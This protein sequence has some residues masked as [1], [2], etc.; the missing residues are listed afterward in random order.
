[1]LLAL[2]HLQVSYVTIERTRLHKFRKNI[3]SFPQDIGSFFARMGALRQYRVGDRVNSNRG[4]PLP[5]ED[6]FRE[7][8]RPTTKE[9]RERFAVDASGHLVFAATVKDVAAD[10]RLV[11]EYTDADGNV[12]GEGVEQPDW[13]RPRV[14][15]P[16]HPS[17]LKEALVIM[18]RRNVGHGRVLEGLEVRWGLVVRVL[19]A[20]TKL[21]LWRDSEVMGPMHAAYDPRLFDVLSEEEVRWKYAPK[22][23]Q[24]ELVTG[25]R[26][27]ELKSQGKDAQALDVRTA[28]EL[29]ASGFSVQL[30][31]M[32]PETGGPEFQ[33]EEVEQEV[34]RKWLEV[35]EFRLGDALGRWWA[36]LPLQED[37]DSRDA[38][39][40]DH[41]D[42]LNDFH[43][44]LVR[45]SSSYLREAKERL[46]NVGV[47]E[48]SFL[49]E[50]SM[51]RA[52][53]SA[54]Q[55]RALA[56]GG[57]VTIPFL[58]LWCRSQKDLAEFAA[59]D[60]ECQDLADEVEAEMRIVSEHFLM[61]ARGC[62]EAAPESNDVEAEALH[63]AE[64]L[65][66]PEV[67]WPRVAEEPTAYKATGRFTRALPL[68]FP[69]GVAD[70][71]DIRHHA[72]T[73]AEWVQ[74][75]F[76]HAAG[77]C[78]Q[79]LRGHREVWAFVN[80]I[81]LQEAAGK[82]FAVQRNV[83]RRI[84]GRFV[85]RRVTTK[86]QLREMIEDEDAVR[87]LVHQLMSVGRDVRST[88]MHWAYEAKKTTCAVNHLSWRPPWVRSRSEA[89]EDD[90][91]IRF[92]GNNERVV[93]GVGLGR[94][95]VFWWT[96]NCA[97]NAAYDIHRLNCIDPDAEKALVDT[98]DKYRHVRYN[99]IRDR[100]DLAA[101]MV[102]FRAE[103]N[104]RIVMPTIVPHSP[105]APYLG[106]ARFE[107]GKGANPHYHGASYGMGNPRLGFMPCEHARASADLSPEAFAAAAA[108]GENAEDGEEVEVESVRP[109]SSSAVD[110]PPAPPPHAEP[111]PQ[112]R[113]LREQ[114]TPEL[115][116]RPMLQ[117]SRLLDTIAA[118]SSLDAQAR[119][120]FRF[121]RR[122]VSEWNPCCAE[123]GEQRVSFSWDGEVG[124]HD[125]VVQEPGSTGDE[126][127]APPYTAGVSTSQGDCEPSRVRLS[128]VLAEVLNP[129]DPNAA[130]DLTKVRRLVSAL[131]Q[132]CGRHDR[133]AK[134]GPILGKHPC[135][136]GKPECPYCRYGFPH[137]R[138]TWAEGMSLEKGEREGQWAAHF[139]RNDGLVNSHEV[140]VLLANMGNIDWR[141][142]LN[143][144][145]VVEYICKYAT[146][147]PEGSKKLGEM[148]GDAVDEVCKY[149]R[150]GEPVDFLRKSL[151][152]LYTR[153]LG[154]RDYTIFEAMFLGL[155]LPLMLSLMPVV[156]LNTT[157]TRALK[158]VAQM[159]NAGPDAEIS[160]RSKVDKFDE[161]LCLL[162]RQFPRPEQDPLRLHWEGLIR[163]TSLQEFYWKYNV[164]RG[165]LHKTT[166]DVCIMVTPAVSAAAAC[167]LHDRHD[168]YART[169]V[170]AYWRCMPSTDRARLWN[171]MAIKEPWFF[172]GTVL[173]PP[174]PHAGA[175]PS[176]QDRFVGVQD[177]VA[178]FDE[179]RR[180]EMVWST[181]T[182][183][184]AYP[185]RRRRFSPGVT[186]GWSFALMEMLVDPVLLEW[187][188]EYVVEQYKRWNPYFVD[189]LDQVTS[190]WREKGAKLSPARKTNRL[191]L[192]KVRARMEAAQKS[193][194]G[195][196]KK[197]EDEQAARASGSD[198]DPDSSAGA[199]SPDEAEQLEANARS[200]L[201]QDPLPTLGD[202]GPEGESAPDDWAKATAEERLSA[203]GPCQ[204]AP[205]KVLSARPLVSGSCAGE[206]NPEGYDWERENFVPRG[207]ALKLQ[208]LW[209]SWC[210]QDVFSADDLQGAGAA[211]VGCQEDRLDPW[212]AFARDI[213]A[214]RGVADPGASPPL[215]LIMTGT[216]GTGK[217]RT[218]KAAVRARCLRRVMGKF[219]AKAGRRVCVLAAPTGC[220]SFQL[221]NGATTVHRAFG[222]PVGF[223]GK[224]KNRQT[225]AF[226]RRQGRLRA[227]EVF[228]IDEFSMVGRQMMGKIVFKVRECL[229]GS[230][231]LG[232]KDAVLSGDP[233]QAAPIGE[234]P[235]FR[236]GRYEG[237]GL[238]KPRKGDAP[239]G[240]PSLADL[241]RM[242]E[243]LREE[244]QD[245]VILRNV[246]R[247]CRA[248][249]GMD[250]AAAAQYEADADR[251]LEVTQ[252]M[253]N[254]TWTLQDHAWLARRN[255]SALSKT[256]EGRAKLEA[257]VEAPLLMDGKRQ[258]RQG[259]D[260][261]TRLNQEELFRMAAR[262][263]KPVLGIPAFHGGYEQGSLPE[264]M[265]DEDFKGLE[266][267]LMLCVGARVLLTNNLWVEA[268]LM[269]GAL[270]TVRGFIWPEGGDPRAASRELRA[271]VCVVVEFDEIDLGEEPAQDES[272]NP[273]VRDGR[274]V[275][276]R[277]CF[278][279]SLVAAMGT[280]TAGIP[281]ACR[282]VPIYQF[283][284]T[285]ESDE[286]VSRHQFPLVLAWALTHWKA[287]G[288][289]LRRA[290]IRMGQRTASQPGIGFV[291]NTRVKHPTHM[292]FDTDLPA[293][294][295]F[296]EAQW[297]QNFRAR[298]RFEW[299]L[300]AKASHTLRKYGF[301]G[302]DEWSVKDASIAQALLSRLEK[303]GLER[304]RDMGLGS[305]PDAW[306]WPSDQVP[307]EALLLRQVREHAGDDAEL[308]AQTEQ[309][310]QRLLGPWHKPA[311]LEA[312]G[313]LIPGAFHPRH[314]G[315]KPRGK[316]GR[317]P[318]MAVHLQA[319]PWK[320]DAFEEQGLT[321]SAPGAEGRLLKGVLEF[322]LIVLRR[323]CER[324]SLPI[325][326]GTHRLGYDLQAAQTEEDMALMLLTL[327]SWQQWERMVANTAVAEA[328]LVPVALDDNNV[329]RDC[330]L[331]TV[332]PLTAGQRLGEAL[333]YKVDVYDVVGRSSLAERLCRNM[334]KLLSASHSSKEVQLEQHL[335]TGGGTP[336]ERGFASMG[337]LL[338]S[339][340]AKAGL[341][342]HDPV[343]P[344]FAAKVRKSL[345]AC[346]ASLRSEADKRGN[347]DVLTQLATAEACKACLQVL[348]S[349]QEVQVST[350]AMQVPRQQPRLKAVTVST[351]QPLKVL[352]W[353]ISGADKSSLAPK[354]FSMVDKM[355]AIQQEI[356]SRW[357]PDVCT[358]QECVDERP[359]PG[360]V[361]TYSQVGVAPAEHSGYI[362][363]YV[364]QGLCAELLTAPADCP[365]VLA[366]ITVSEGTVF[367]V[368]AV[369]LMPGECAKKERKAQLQAAL[370]KMRPGS[371]LLL[372]DM[373]VRPEEVR[374]L[375]AMGH[376]H[377]AEYAGRSWHPSK[378]RYDDSEEL[379]AYRGPGFAFDRV[380]FTGALCVET[381]LLGQGRVY[382]EGVCFSLS[383]HFAV[384]GLVDLHASHGAAA[385]GS[386]VRRERR[387]ALTAVRDQVCF[388]E[389][390]VVSEMS[391]EGRQEAAAQWARTDAKAQA[392]AVRVQRAQIKE[393]KAG[394][395]AL[396]AD[397]FGPQSAFHGDGSLKDLP[398]TASEACPPVGPTPCLPPLAPWPAET[399]GAAHVLAQVFL[400]LGVV[401]SWLQ[402]HTRTCKLQR[403]QCMCCALASMGH[404]FQAEQAK[405]FQQVA[406]LSVT[407]DLRTCARQV[408]SALSAKEEPRGLWAGVGQPPGCTLTAVDS[409][410]AFPQEVCERCCDCGRISSR[411]EKELVMDLPSPRLPTTRRSVPDLYIQSCCPQQDKEAK[412]C[413]SERCAGASTVHVR[414]ARAVRLPD[415]L[416]VS[417]DRAAGEGVGSRYPVHADDY[418]S[419]HG[420][421]NAELAAVVYGMS[422][423]TGRGRYTCAIRGPD[424]CFW[425]F[426]G[427]RPPRRLQTDIADLCSHAVE[428]LVYLPTS[429][430]FASQAVLGQVLRMPAQ[431]PKSED[432]LPVPLGRPGAVGHRPTASPSGQP[433]RM[434]ASSAGAKPA[435]KKEKLATSIRDNPLWHMLEL[436]SLQ[437][438]QAGE[439]ELDLE[440]CFDLPARPKK[441]QAAMEATRLWQKLVEVLHIP[442][443]V[444]CGLLAA[445]RGRF[446]EEGAWSL[447]NAAWICDLE[448][449][450]HF[451]A[452]V[453]AICPAGISEAMPLVVRP[454]EEVIFAVVRLV[455]LQQAA[456][457]PVSTTDQQKLDELAAAGWQR[458]SSDAWDE[459]DCLVDSLAQV[460]EA[461]GIIAG[462]GPSGS[463]TQADRKNACT[464]ARQHL[465]GDPALL[466]RDPYGRPQWDAYLQ[467][468]RHAETLV[469][470]LVRRFSA[471]QSP[472]PRAGATLVVHAR[473][474]TASV[475]AERVQICVGAGQR[476]PAPELHLFNW[477]GAGLRGYHYDALVRSGSGVHFEPLLREQSTAGSSNDAALAVGA[478]ASSSRLKRT[479][480]DGRG[481][482]GHN[483]PEVLD[484][485]SPPRHALPGNASTAVLDSPRP[486]AKAK[487]QAQ[488]RR[489]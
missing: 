88:P 414:Q 406:A 2:E 388:Q 188:P 27:E 251:F 211:D 408:L 447:S 386:E 374:D 212:Q 305:D 249:E 36:E 125:V 127:G 152:K 75:M 216:A 102:A 369:H 454:A 417:V 260:G 403:L 6:D 483:A 387:G 401:A 450:S 375:L 391:R 337:V 287:Q 195:E 319:G 98:S 410:F 427:R 33:D 347:R 290:R 393:R 237:K 430:S 219:D 443:D 286:K 197:D 200:L 317:E 192:R 452:E 394:R 435:G 433:K 294:E 311:V 183:G 272:G 171:A 446:G 240:A 63:L 330:V 236:Y 130:V 441:K 35:R 352:S 37:E 207:Q 475:P 179:R 398:S 193:K 256:P 4:P 32:D 7:A 367:D 148:L 373:N 20:L 178:A 101:Y 238:N 206:V 415:V 384:M 368:A 111:R 366:R 382:S 169:C 53:L 265:F 66:A 361:A 109:V 257:F 150:D 348:S 420:C 226:A 160:W 292:V 49:L 233:K 223:C 26:A 291:A 104:M 97:Y 445:L 214:R 41:D 334:V 47:A 80:T 172:G 266:A 51:Q 411:Y 161:R 68:S 30:L 424:T 440:P 309:V 463:L 203:A 301:C 364:R 456:E 381:F 224:A 28:A 213:I 3:I 8:R 201:V 484:L 438:A 154:G 149:T 488:P 306:C 379:K 71:Y 241:T 329:L 11:L 326:L 121:F 277:R 162:R 196:N 405:A 425:F 25:E 350:S 296:Q 13:V 165:R 91:R 372:G 156:S 113:V 73:E 293:W 451:G 42:N 167:V 18:L 482:A 76:R 96:Q 93:D 345:G 1:M 175:R 72:V 70:M 432:G 362:H 43:A 437:A 164:Y 299:R 276:Q 9:E 52:S 147:A 38:L 275:Y 187:V 89:E 389:Q 248:P 457:I 267:I 390:C 469:W 479:P 434:R 232:G 10:G 473:Y 245:V 40:T 189:F 413:P 57:K 132:K 426:D 485:S 303:K 185:F 244:F 315:K 422:P 468:H 191:F 327:Q 77:L 246:H 360:L 128:E 64:S 383:D 353:N 242:G 14:Q 472:L 204:A 407:A 159:Q 314:D 59:D 470:F 202:D 228:I 95:P 336:Y 142:C 21:G 462:S 338:A 412:A 166:Q 332:A 418:I 271:P 92:L 252:G 458:R 274:V 285:A 208:G 153:T 313:C 409:L 471:G 307:V 177:L 99:F 61:S 62:M 84:G 351:F 69:M 298:R 467:H 24:G 310:A 133:H 79:G 344:D 363:L 170:V 385:H 354:S 282:C 395:D 342:F 442:A 328:F 380:F 297:K 145:A 281:R 343:A 112:K 316:P 144:W 184:G 94:I 235:M 474:D 459:N 455:L 34:F 182:Q 139:P 300:E 486:K 419:L 116:Q 476:G 146:K 325:V 278:F 358:L 44:Q 397:A 355:A 56:D 174:L 158:T 180:E 346:F 107:C 231:T 478:A 254:C 268:G 225:V 83:M 118:E 90:D 376:L 349:P 78:V 124:A 428:L 333:G 81:L 489:P 284:T 261:S 82:G 341:V 283:K 205:D 356:C 137:E 321:G 323:I 141:P 269:N 460:L 74:H 259:E 46:A 5:D 255:R 335:L 190:E 138:R 135:A 23:W 324:L 396:L 55:M 218:I 340:L 322:F 140:H 209:K 119:E 16:W 230:A 304:R 157:G 280:D 339:V 15:M 221:K 480:R 123:D 279:P 357:K 199:G 85:G 100:P 126:H 461:L 264:L 308:A 370:R 168:I 263:D 288:M 222:V 115:T 399:Q 108:A 270:G 155:R 58:V 312:L 106:L 176:E 295:H 29:Q 117:P 331:I 377:D 163:D 134:T 444:V 400:R 402:Q 48:E 105:E 449:W 477:T 86:A 17:Q 143:L 243:L 136:R 429:A 194:Q 67:G 22:A 19:Q 253:A 220:A 487:T 210:D 217:S 110:V 65:A 229:P 464:A 60:V 262:T 39:K 481:R 392:A 215:R 12:L 50:A 320:I 423:Q 250:A 234:E 54:L 227:A 151:Q 186:Y 173:E 181:P 129:M 404:T 258:N 371:Q 302:A 103:L 131:V 439:D 466:P 31:G 365:A 87:T 273:L 247:I 378:S 453:Q 289:T 122:R 436:S 431:V 114:R 359:L 448:N 120:F 416:L 198:S 45:Q 239:D 318:G 421:G 465:M